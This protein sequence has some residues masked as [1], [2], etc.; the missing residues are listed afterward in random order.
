MLNYLQTVDSLIRRSV[1]SRLR[2]VKWTLSEWKSDGSINK[3]KGCQKEIIF[4]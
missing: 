3:I 4:K 1:A 2:L